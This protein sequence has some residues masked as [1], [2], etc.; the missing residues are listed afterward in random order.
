MRHPRSIC[1][2]VTGSLFLSVVGCAGDSLPSSSVP[3]R[4]T[5]QIAQT[6]GEPTQ[7]LSGGVQEPG[8][9]PPPSGTAPPAAAREPAQG[10]QG[11]PQAGEVQ[12]RTVV[13]FRPPPPMIGAAPLPPCSVGPTQNLTKVGCAIQ[14]KAKSLTTLVVVAPGLALT[15]PVSI[16][17]GYASPWG[18]NRITQ[19][20]VA[21]TGNQFLYNDPAGDGKP[22]NM[23][24]SIT[25]SEPKPGGGVYNFPIQ[26]N[27]MLDPLYDVTITPLEFTLFSDC[28]VVGGGYDLS[29]GWASPDGA[30]HNFSFHTSAGQHV[31]VGGFAWARAEVSA[32]A[33]LSLP[34]GLY[35]EANCFLPLGC[36]LH[37]VD[38]P[39]YPSLVPGTSRQVVSTLN[40]LHGQ[41][42]ASGQYNITYQLRWYPYL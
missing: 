32:S 35:F 22:R 10:P 5:S 39:P 19:T 42:S 17:I 13:P 30:S 38:Q 27:V 9:V 16:S 37:G 34:G 40:D 11:E 6:S 12:E 4:P 23:A 29:F 21:S 20:Y 25:L 15:Q 1:V 7:P 26:A 33:N 28:S 18:G 24:V 3:P 2:V 31:T 8:T 36:F 14:M 41:C